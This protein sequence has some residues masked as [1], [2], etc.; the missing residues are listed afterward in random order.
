MAQFLAS[1]NAFRDVLRQR[2]GQRTA[3]TAVAIARHRYGPSARSH[4]AIGFNHHA[5]L[6]ANRNG[7]RRVEERRACPSLGTLTRLV[8]SERLRRHA[9]RSVHARNQGARKHA[10]YDRTNR[11]DFHGIERSHHNL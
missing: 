8:V 11:R 3:N 9:T 1:K 7:R 4:G 10:L 2:H 6:Q 5:T